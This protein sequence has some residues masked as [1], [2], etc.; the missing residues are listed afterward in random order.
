MDRRSERQYRRMLDVIR[1]VRSGHCSLVMAA[2]TLLALRNEV[3]LGGRVANDFTSLILT[4]ESAGIDA[5]TGVLPPGMSLDRSGDI[6]REGLAPFVL[7]ALNHL[8]RIVQEQLP[9]S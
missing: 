5:T 1:E 7:E 3:N 6:H 8:E 4:L 2:D 9:A